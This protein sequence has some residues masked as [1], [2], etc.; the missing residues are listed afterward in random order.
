SAGGVL[1]PLQ[2]LHRHIKRPALL[3]Q[4]TFSLHAHH[5]S[6]PRPDRT[7]V[8]DHHGRHAILSKQHKD[9]V[10]DLELLFWR[11]TPT[12]LCAQSETSSRNQHQTCRHLPALS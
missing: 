5:P 6:A 7:P 8:L 9:V 2:L 11:T 12:P 1:L 4:A 3:L 10:T